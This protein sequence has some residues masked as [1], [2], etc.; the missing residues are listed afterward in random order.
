MN[1]SPEEIRELKELLP[2]HLH[3]W[4]GYMPT[5]EP[6]DEP[7]REERRGMARGIK[8]PATPGAPAALGARPEA[9]KPKAEFRGLQ[10]ADKETPLTPDVQ[11]VLLD[12]ALSEDDDAA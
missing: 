8:P 7:T 2:E 1:L 4:I 9:R 11:R 10:K 5:P 6:E 12:L 3:R